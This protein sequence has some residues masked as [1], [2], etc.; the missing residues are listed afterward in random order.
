LYSENTEEF[1]F[2]QDV[3]V[4]PEILSSTSLGYQHPLYIYL[5]RQFKHG[6]YTQGRITKKTTFVVTSIRFLIYVHK[7]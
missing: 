1:R 4:N 5:L 6:D 3:D 2:D 7:V